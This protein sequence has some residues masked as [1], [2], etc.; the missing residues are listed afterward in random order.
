MW[1]C[2]SGKYLDDALHAAGL[3][4]AYCKNMGWTYEHAA[5]T[6]VMDIT[7]AGLVQQFAKATSDCDAAGTRKIAA[8][9][10]QWRSVALTNY[11]LVSL[12]FEH[13]AVNAS[14][15]KPAIA[16]ISAFLEMN[17]R[18]FNAAPRLRTIVEIFDDSDS[19]PEFR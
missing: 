11:I 16:D 6:A 9:P 3:I 5:T 8:H 1:T 12:Q 10:S 7:F 14:L 13:L 18:N 19:G 4:N 2:R 15:R 17:P